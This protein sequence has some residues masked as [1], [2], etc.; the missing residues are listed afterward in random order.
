[1]VGSLFFLLDSHLYPPMSQT[2]HWLLL[3]TNVGFL[4][5]FLLPTVIGCMPM[6]L[7]NTSFGRLASAAVGPESGSQKSEVWSYLF[8]L[9][10][11]SSSV[12]ISLRI[13]KYSTDII[14]MILLLPQLSLLMPRHH[15]KSREVESFILPVQLCYKQADASSFLYGAYAIEV[16]IFRISGPL[17]AAGDVLGMLLHSLLAPLVLSSPCS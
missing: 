8:P 15:V 13:K 11:I 12:L 10:G 7:Q 4:V 2:M 16:D 9:R 1:M 3:P 6:I 5:D 17:L 14:M